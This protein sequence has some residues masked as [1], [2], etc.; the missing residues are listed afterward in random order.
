[1]NVN[2]VY[3][4]DA[5]ISSPL[6]LTMRQLIETHQLEQL[7]EATRKQSDTCTISG[8]R[9]IGDMKLLTPAPEI[10]CM[11]AIYLEH[12]RAKG[13]EPYQE[14]VIFLKPHVSLIDPG[15]PIKLRKHCPEKITFGAKLCLI[16]GREGRNVPERDWMKYVTGFTI[17]TDVTARGLKSPGGTGKGMCH[18]KLRSVNDIDREYFSQLISEAAGLKPRK[19]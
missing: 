5:D 10:I 13:S 8:Y 1:M 12:Q 16:I 7:K 11:G 2:D 19:R 17:L 15:D 9:R 6:A 3:M 18:I 4:N 14:P